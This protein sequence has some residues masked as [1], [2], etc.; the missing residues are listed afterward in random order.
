ML[1]KLCVEHCVYG[2]S[3]GAPLES[4]VEKLKR[5]FSAS[6]E[7]LGSVDLAMHNSGFAVLIEGNLFCLYE[8]RGQPAIHALHAISR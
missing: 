5:G 6:G 3:G 2:S 8:G 1:R 4:L 7:A